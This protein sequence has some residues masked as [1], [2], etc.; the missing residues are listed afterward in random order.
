MP[1]HL[2]INSAWCFSQFSL[3]A[4]SKFFQFCQP[5][6]LA[7]PVLHFNRISSFL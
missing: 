7:L 6:H 1:W 2:S 4:S 5:S 3:H